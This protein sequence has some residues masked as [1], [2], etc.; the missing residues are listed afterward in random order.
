MKNLKKYILLVSLLSFTLCS[1]KKE[2]E[3][4]FNMFDVTVDFH[5]NTPYSVIDYKEVMVDDS[6]HI[7][8]TLKSPDKDMYKVCL[9]ETGTSTPLITVP[10]NDASLR[11]EF[12]YRFKVKANKKVGKT[13]YRVYPLDKG[14]VYMGDGYKS[15]TVN[16]KSD[17]AYYTE[18]FLKFPTVFSSYTPVLTDSLKSIDSYLSLTTGQVFNYS[19]GA[20]NSEKIDLGFRLYFPAIVPPDTTSRG[21]FQIY[22]MGATTNPVPFYDISSWTRKATLF[23]IPKDKGKAAFDKLLTGAQLKAVALK[24][25][26]E[27]KEPTTL[28]GGDYIFYFKTPEGRYGAVCVLSL[29]TLKGGADRSGFQIAANVHIKVLNN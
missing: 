21:V 1:C 22:S 14:G 6:I 13:T 3:H 8:V 15:V 17:F 18:R 28:P 4:I 20:G 16:V 2:G 29:G 9:L 12:S 7:D 10:I 26:I 23:S 25:K 27:L 5:G 24:E 11:R 19:V